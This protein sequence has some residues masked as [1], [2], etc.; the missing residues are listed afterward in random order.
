[1]DQPQLLDTDM[2]IRLSTQ[3]KDLIERAAAAELRKPS[4]FLR[5]LALEGLA[6]RGL[7]PETRLNVVRKDGRRGEIKRC[8][9][10]AWKP[11]W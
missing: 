6:A 4:D 1:M 10:E 8:E 7:L 2:H 9:L 3:Q 11:R 5:V